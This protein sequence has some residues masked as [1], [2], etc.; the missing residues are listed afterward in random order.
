MAVKGLTSGSPCSEGLL[1]ITTMHLNLSSATQNTFNPYSYASGHLL[2]G[3]VTG[4]SVSVTCS[5][6]AAPTQKSLKTHRTTTLRWRSLSLLQLTSPSMGM[7]LQGD[8]PAWL[9]LAFSFVLLE[10]MGKGW[11]ERSFSYLEREWL[12]VCVCVR[13]CVR[14]CM[15]ACVCAS[16]YACMC[17]CMHVCVLQIRVNLFWLFWL[18]LLKSLM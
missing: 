15:R 12:C 1:S 10:K 6:V 3:D 5:L 16:V 11:D 2:S 7:L 18:G 4:W 14:A 8:V 17:A 9:V 13:A